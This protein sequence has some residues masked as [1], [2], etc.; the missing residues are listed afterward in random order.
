MKGLAMRVVGISALFV[1]TGFSQAVAGQEAAPK[2]PKIPTAEKSVPN[3]TAKS[4]ATLAVAQDL[5]QYARE[6]KSAL[7]MLV[8]V[9][10]MR[11]ASARTD[12][13]RLQQK[14]TAGTGRE[15]QKSGSVAKADAEGLLA[16]AKGWAGDD[17]ALTALLDQEAGKGKEPATRGRRGGPGCDKGTVMAGDAVRYRIDFKPREMAAVG[18]LGD[19]DTDLDCY[20]F[21][22]AENL[23][24]ADE[25]TSPHCYLQWYT[26]N[27]GVFTIV[28]SNLRGSVYN[29]Y[30]ICTN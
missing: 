29:N 21:D 3:E 16:E 24:R 18:V 27:G 11:Q 19:G 12:E 2:V 23:L 13:T 5:V 6:N 28:V 4:V 1:I 15:S 30:T 25:S 20:V 22:Q 26:Q 10:M 7:T 9:Q 8:A 17:K 14:S